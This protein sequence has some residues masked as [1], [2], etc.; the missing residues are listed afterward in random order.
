MVKPKKVEEERKRKYKLK[1]EPEQER[2][3]ERIACMYRMDEHILS[4][5][6]VCAEIRVQMKQTAK[7]RERYKDK[8]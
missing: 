2:K 4:K 6:E 1:N 3:D 8:N 5:K 7:K